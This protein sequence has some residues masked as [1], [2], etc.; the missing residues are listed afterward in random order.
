MWEAIYHFLLVVCNSISILQF[1]RYYHFYS[2]RV[3]LWPWKVLT[4]D[5]T[6]GIICHLCLTLHGKIFKIL[7]QRLTP[8]QRSTL[9][10]SNVAKFVRREIGD[11]VPYL[12]HTLKKQ[13]SDCLSNC[14]HCADRAQNLPGT[15]PN[16]WLILFQI[17]SK[18]V[19][20]RQSYSR[21]RGDRFC[22]T[23][24]FMKGLSSL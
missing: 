21:T 14:H 13:N 9:L 4:F 11:I 7:F 16:I 12:P 2:V 8:P 20:F 18:S 6:V 3:W 22:L 15:A 17:S 5:T 10:C 1:S 19:H 24:Y 23:E